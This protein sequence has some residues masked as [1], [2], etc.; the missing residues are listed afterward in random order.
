MDP[1]GR[2]GVRGK[3]CGKIQAI[4]KCNRVLVLVISQ[5]NETN[6][7]DFTEKSFCDHRTSWPTGLPLSK[8]KKLT[9]LYFLVT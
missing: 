7:R 9:S 4:N 5:E 1:L 2:T 8:N 6:E 3:W